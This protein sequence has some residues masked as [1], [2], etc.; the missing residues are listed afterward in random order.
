MVNERWQRIKELFQIAG[1]LPDT[2]RL[3]FLDELPETDRPLRNDVEN[4]LAAQKQRD[5]FLESPP[6][7]DMSFLPV[8]IEEDI[9]RRIGTTIGPYRIVDLIGYGGMGAVYR[10]ERSDN[11][12][13][14]ET[15]LKIVKRGMDT[16][17]IVARFRAERQILATLEH[18]HIARLLDGGATEDG[19]PFFVMEYV[20]GI[21]ITSYCDEHRLSIDDRLS[22][23]MQVCQAVRFAHNN[24]IVH[25][26]LKPSNI[27]VKNDGTVKLLDFGIA[28]VISDAHGSKGLT[29]TQS[30]LRLLT[31]EYAS[32]EQ[33][34]GGRI[35]TASD[36]YSLGIL[37]YELLTGERPYTIE[38]HAGTDSGPNISSWNPEKP[39]TRFRSKRSR[40][41][42][43]T[44]SGDTASIDE[45]SQHRGSSP[46]RIIKKLSGDLDNIVLKAIRKEPGRRYQSA[47][48]ILNDLN[49]YMS[50][51]PVTARPDTAL[52]RARKFARRHKT[53]VIAFF[54][55]MLSLLSG[56]LLALHQSRIANAERMRAEQRFDDVR[57]LANAFIFEFHDAIADLPGSTR[58]RELLVER[59]IQYLNSLTLETERDPEILRELILAYQRIGDVQG[60]PT[61]PNLGKV[62]DALMSYRKAAEIGTQ[63]LQL[64]PN[65]PEI[66]RSLALVHEKMSD[67]EAW[68]GNL[69]QGVVYARQALAFFERDA[70]SH[71]GVPAKRLSL[72]ISLIKLGDILG[73]PNFPN[74]GDL[75]SAHVSYD[76]SYNILKELHA[77]DSGD[78]RTA[79]YLGLILERLGS[80]MEAGGESDKALGF[81]YQSLEIRNDFAKKNPNHTDGIRDL[82]VAHEKIGNIHMQKEEPVTAL[83]YYQFSHDL[84]R[85]LARADTSN[86]QAQLSLA[87]SHIKL[88]EAYETG[89]IRENTLDRTGAETNYLF[90]LHILKRLSDT[91]SDHTMV[92]GLLRMVNSRISGRQTRGGGGESSP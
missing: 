49:R 24:L 43:S 12:F 72:A 57:N 35:S 61:N 63:L 38:R 15:A 4:L 75:E 26:D 31:P 3:R 17:E 56:M 62:D 81:Y 74:V 73:N 28:R 64:R 27:L 50:N 45:R 88:A 48:E 67:L 55:I 90:A 89:T 84:F 19:L 29:A 46:D 1:E 41:G 42:Q 66:H 32:P 5:D 86:I 7:L 79:R 2:E 82:A 6:L 8:S 18:P 9:D 21:P 59:G 76:R 51:M 77:A 36:V 58:A 60:N 71:P 20:D 14:K 44:G 53:A 22:L 40:I 80:I 10:A 87:I 52:Y 54:L 33:I 16:D 68:Q 92:D 91:G 69:D 37:L 25:R 78:R 65:D 13:Y 83:G 34:S 47:E 30:G 70:D 11:Q 39:S 85:G 23:F